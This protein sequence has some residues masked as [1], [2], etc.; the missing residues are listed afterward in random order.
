MDKILDNNEKMAK[1]VV[2]INP[3]ASLPSLLK[4]VSGISLCWLLYYKYFY[5]C[6]VLIIVI[7]VLIRNVVYSQ[8]ASALVS[9]IQQ[10][11]PMADQE[12]FGFKVILSNNGLI[13]AM[14][15]AQH[16]VFY[17]TQGEYLLDNRVQTDF[18]N[19]KGQHTSTILSDS[20]VVDREGT[21]ISARKNVTVRSD[22]GITIKTEVLYWGNKDKK[23][24][25]DQFVTIFSMSDTLNGLGFTSDQN[26]QNWQIKKPQGV[27][28]RTIRIPRENQ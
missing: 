7:V 6:F 19:P 5:H 18:Y 2:R 26:L 16:M 22:S 13:Y 10:N 12:T 20:A 8:N 25:T 9:T 14:V 11:T 1:T 27:S 24:F 21:S 23:I 15:Q 28:G 4:R 3:P 17:R